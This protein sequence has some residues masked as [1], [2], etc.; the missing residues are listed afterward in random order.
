MSSL[1]PQCPDCSDSPLSTTANI[2]GILTFMVSLIIPSIVFA[3]VIR[4]VDK[5]LNYLIHSLEEIGHEIKYTRDYYHQFAV[6]ADADLEAM[7][8]IIK[9]NLEELSSTQIRLYKRL[10]GEQ[11]T[12]G[13]LSTRIKWWY[14]EKDATAAEMF[15]LQSRKHHFTTLQIIFLMKQVRSQR[16]S[17]ERTE[18]NTYILRS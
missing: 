8:S 5:E 10:Q 15:Q 11:K 12:I 1:C 4:D 17:I 7:Q 2:L 13:N 16:G 6:E 9:A 3:T 18:R 14:K